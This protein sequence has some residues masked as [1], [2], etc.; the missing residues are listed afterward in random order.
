MTPDS[1][2]LDLLVL[3]GLTIDRFEDGASSAGGSVLHIARAA[4]SRGLRVGI[5]TG[6]GPEPEAVAG[7]EELHL[8]AT[9]VDGSPQAGTTSFR[10]RE[11]AEGRRLWLG[12]RG[13]SLG[14]GADVLARFDARAV[15]YAPVAGEVPAEAL[16]ASDAAL[17]RGA[18]LQGWLRTTDEGEEVQPL[19][20]SA[21]SG[22]LAGALRDFDLLVASREDLLAEGTEPE[23]QLRSMRSAFG[24]G[25]TL[26]VTDG[27]NG[28]WIGL[29]P[30][31]EPWHLP[32][33]RRVEDVPS[34]GSGDVLAAFMLVGEWRR[35]PDASFVRQRAELAMQ[36]VAEMLEERRG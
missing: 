8:L 5:V 7:M 26:V 23:L 12:V 15:L 34:V 25:S 18:I 22:A 30:D 20:L 19:P 32:V 11:A 17:T 9:I 13:A 21:L 2:P 24:S 29:E 28:V 4:A 27:P 14:S 35:P 3:G 36:V 31:G 10:H 6:A 33:P 16:A 1:P